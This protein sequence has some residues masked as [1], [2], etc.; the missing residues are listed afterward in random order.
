MRLLSV[1]KGNIR[2]PMTNPTKPFKYHQT[3]PKPPREKVF[4]SK[5]R[6]A[7]WIRVS[8]WLEDELGY[9]DEKEVALSIKAMDTTG[10]IWDKIKKDI[11]ECEDHFREEEAKT[12]RIK[13][14]YQ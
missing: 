10:A 2:N 11:E 8:D 14:A 4:R 6:E 5:I 9:S 7:V 13:E 1:T 3:T 12:K